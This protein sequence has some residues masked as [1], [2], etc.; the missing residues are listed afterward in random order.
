MPDNSQDQIE[1]L[2]QQLVLLFQ[3][4]QYERRLA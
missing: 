2:N 1:Q 4:G 3:Q